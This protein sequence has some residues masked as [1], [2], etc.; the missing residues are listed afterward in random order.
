MRI[1]YYIVTKFLVVKKKK[2]FKLKYASIIYSKANDLF[3][4]EVNIRI[5]DILAKIEKL[6]YFCFYYKILFFHSSI[7]W[8]NKFYFL[9]EGTQ[10]GFPIPNPRDPPGTPMDLIKHIF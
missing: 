1:I 10:P 7:Y 2:T 3:Q 9:I 6:K 8:K 4:I 5:F